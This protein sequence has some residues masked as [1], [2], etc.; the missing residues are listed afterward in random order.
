MK[1]AETRGDL[2]A[3]TNQWQHREKQFQNNKINS[4]FD[5]KKKKKQA[6]QMCN[7]DLFELEEV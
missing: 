7:F 6:Q 2:Q 5:V 1:H 4:V 3:L